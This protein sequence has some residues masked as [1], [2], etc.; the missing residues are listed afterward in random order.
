[1]LNADDRVVETCR[2]TERCGSSGDGVAGCPLPAAE[3]DACESEASIATCVD[4]HDM[5]SLSS[6][7][8]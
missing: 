7:E 2:E 4:V 5:R 8:D 6:S 1:V 3:G